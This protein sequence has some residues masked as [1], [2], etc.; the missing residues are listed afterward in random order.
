MRVGPLLLAFILTIPS[1]VAAQNSTA[2]GVR[3][4][5]LGDFTAAARILQPLAEERPDADPIAAFFLATLYHS[6]AIPGSDWLR[7]CGMYLRAAVPGSPLIFQAT[8]LAADTHGGSAALY[9]ICDMARARGWGFPQP[10]RF[11]LGRNH[12]VRIDQGG[13]FVEHE[14]AETRSNVQWGGAGWKF[15]PTRLTEIAP[16]GEP[17]RYFVEIFVWMPDGRAD[18]PHW[19][20]TWFGYEVV[21]KD[22]YP[23]PGDG[24]VAEMVGREPPASVA[25]DDLA[26][27]V[28]NERGDVARVAIGPHAQVVLIPRRV[29]P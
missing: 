23:I 20:L 7:A 19:Y 12:A 10:A 24:T 11:V 22:T 18:E 1:H 25:I 6:N 26:R 5:F 17:R 27:I 13:M 3:A 21:G 14:G 15:L 28:L 2:D 4:F 16:P 9:E 29:T 8:A